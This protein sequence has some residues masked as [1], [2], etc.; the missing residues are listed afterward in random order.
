[1][2]R[3]A[4]HRSYPVTWAVDD[5]PVRAGKLELSPSG[6]RLEGGDPRGRLYSLSLRYRDLAGVYVA[7]L[8]TERIRRLPTLIVDRPGSGAIRIATIGGLGLTTEV[9]ERL[10]LL[11]AAA[12]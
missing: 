7:R 1:M 6:L 8:A 4:D 9:F 5:G 10:G 12:T 2:K 11:I 3:G